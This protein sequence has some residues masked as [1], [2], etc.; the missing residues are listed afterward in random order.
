MDKTNIMLWT[1]F[2]GFFTLQLIFS[3]KSKKKIIRLI[4]LL[5]IGIISIVTMIFYFTSGNNIGVTLITYG[6]NMALIGSLTGIGVH[7]ILEKNKR[8]KLNRNK[9]K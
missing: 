2:L 9:A 1:I 5:T 8:K 7:P 6:L 3:Y 4:P